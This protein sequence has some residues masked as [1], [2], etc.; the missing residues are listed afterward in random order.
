MNRRRAI[1]LVAG[2]EISERLASRAVRITTLLMTLAVLAGVIVPGLV[3]SSAKTTRIGLV[4]APAEALEASLVATGRAA[5][6]TVRV[7]RVPSEPAARTQVKGGKL[8]VALVAESG[9]ATAIVSHTLSTTNRALVTTTL[10]AA[11]SH[12]VFTAAGVPPAVVRAARA[13][14]PLTVVA[15]SPPPSH[16]AA[17]AVAAIAAGLFLYVI[18]A[19]YGSAVATG[20]AQEKTSRT[21]EVLISAMRPE[22]L[23]AG[24]VIGI[25]TAGLGQLAI[26][27]AA[28]LIANAIQGSAK[29]PSEIWFLLPSILLFFVLGYALYS[30]AYAAAGAT[31]ARQEEVQFSTAPLGFPLLASYLL[32]YVLIGNTHS[33]L[34][35]VLSFVPPL[36]PALMPAR[37][38][39][40]TVA[41]WEV[42]LGVLIMLVSIYGMVQLA[43]RIYKATL[44]RSGPRLTWREALR[45]RP[46]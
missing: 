44:V 4:G 43:T 32:I 23:L 28:G 40:G 13:P 7:V 30:L 19:M 34:I 31:V 24:K 12:A 20:V 3:H 33:A 26:P 41:W 37:I 9:R 22:D 45:V 2:R 8:D 35:R 16:Q 39:V 27:V 11:H 21:A 10:A 29:I 25:G 38:A 36:T 5:G 14:V 15:I 1:Q 18:L 6:V 46:Q 17:R 42:L